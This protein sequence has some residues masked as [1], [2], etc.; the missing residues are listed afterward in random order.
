MATI[1]TL[2]HYQRVSATAYYKMDLH[3]IFTSFDDFTT[4][5][6][7]KFQSTD[8]QHGMRAKSSPYSEKKK[9]LEGKELTLQ[10]CFVFLIKYHVQ[11]I[12]IIISN[13]I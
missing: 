9:K 3:T 10:Y 11:S 1:E 8:T 4:T 12:M 13:I 5:K 7:T 2:I 6:N